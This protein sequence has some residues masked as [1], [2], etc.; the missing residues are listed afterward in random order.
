M[1]LT[2]KVALV[3]GAISGIGLS[4]VEE[5][6]KNKVRGVIA[7]DIAYNEKVIEDL[8]SKFGDDRV[9][10]VKT[11]ISSKD[12]FENAF[13]E[14]I[15]LFN[16]IDILVNCAGFLNE[17]NWE[18][19]IQVN[20]V[21]TTY[22][23]LLAIHD[24]FPKYKSTDMAYII[25]IASVTGLVPITMLPHYGATK[26][27]VV[28]LTRTLGM[29]EF[30][31]KKG[32]HIVGLC[33]GGTTTGMSSFDPA[34]TVIYKE[35][36]ESQLSDIPYQKPEAVGKSVIDLL[37]KSESGAIWVIN[38]SVLSKTDLPVWEHIEKLYTESHRME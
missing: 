7:A 3:T 29:N 11:D 24:Y 33:P 14:A 5:L 34:T 28:G 8:K 23:C 16:N 20:L 31:T 38:D 13:K 10:Y 35:F 18:K 30:I 21:G 2:D 6:L 17:F 37:Q 1:D 26:Y 9:V 4:T 27:A 25:N 19:E 32:I 15:R 36:L 12:S 22:G